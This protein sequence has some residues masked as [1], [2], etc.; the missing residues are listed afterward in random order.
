M[1]KN[2]LEKAGIK[3]VAKSLDRKTYYDS[4]SQTKNEFDLYWGGW[5][6]RL[7]CPATPRLMPIIFGPVSDGGQN[8]SHLNDPTV[9]AEMT[10]IQEN[11]DIDAANAAW[12]NLDKQIQETITPMVVA[13]NRIG[14]FL[15]GSRWAAPRSIRSSGSSRR[16][17][18]S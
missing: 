7:A 9:K 15:H 6:S 2:A 5:G 3:V 4:I 16:T 10:K 1:I 11:P 14:T 13:E 17:P 18:S 12:M 8:I